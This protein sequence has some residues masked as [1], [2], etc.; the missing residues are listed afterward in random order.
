MGVGKTTFIKAVCKELGVRE[1]VNSPTFSIVNEYTVANDLIIYHFD[2]YSITTR[3]RTPTEF[4]IT[5]IVDTGANSYDGMIVT[6]NMIE[7]HLGFLFK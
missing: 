6:D 7:E 3:R 2:C 1:N 4:T 5:G